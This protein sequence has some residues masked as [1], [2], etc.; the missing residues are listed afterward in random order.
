MVTGKFITFEGPEGGGKSTHIQKL[1]LFLASRGVDVV[2]TREPGGTALGE[3]IRALIQHSVDGT[4]PVDRAELLLFLASRA[5]HV[6]EL[7][8]P[9]LI[10]GRWVLCDRFNDSTLAYQGFG[11]GFDIHQLQLLNNFA[12]NNLK[13]DLTLLIDVSPATSRQRL[14]Q[15]HRGGIS[16]PDRIEAESD[17]FHVRLRDGYLTLAKQEKGRFY[18]VDAEREQ[19]VVEHEICEVIKQRFF[20]PSSTLT[21]P[22]P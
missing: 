13:P 4:A 20:C 14:A 3:K 18:V 1:A 15:R 9:M 5:Q 16:A 19:S 7:I 11:R 17:G 2:A 6:Q 22:T 12:V 8:Q 10:A 21:P